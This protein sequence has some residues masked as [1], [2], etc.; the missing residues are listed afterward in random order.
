M[1]A[2]ARAVL[3]AYLR[4]VVGRVLKGAAA[5]ALNDRVICRNNT[6]GAN[7]IAAL[8][9]QTELQNLTQTIKEH[10][11]STKKLEMTGG[12]Y[13]NAFQCHI[14]N[15]I[16][17]NLARAR[18]AAGHA[19]TVVCETGFNGGHSALLFLL[20][21]P[22]VRYYGWDLADPFGRE[23]S[24]ARTVWASKY[25]SSLL[26]ERFPGKLH[27]TFGDSHKEIFAILRSTSQPAVR[28]RLC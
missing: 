13:T 24:G 1:H 23:A 14:Y 9:L 26:A 15:R 6:F 7:K 21:H 28:R 16:L 10:R 18:Q 8:G 4:C 19:T 22:S 3:L 17:S 27:V 5:Y 25:A 20:S 11:G 2:W 12:V